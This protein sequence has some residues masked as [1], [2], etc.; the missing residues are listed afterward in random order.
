MITT[1]RTTI[2][3]PI[4]L[5]QKIQTAAFFQKK[6]V[7]GLLTD[8]ARCVLD[9]KDVKPGDGIKGLINAADKYGKVRKPYTFNRK[10][11]YD[12]DLKHRG[13]F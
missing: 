9:I 4:D 6:S 11:L 12:E 2:T 3:L 10:K 7:S 1:V 8:G 5:Y 13:I